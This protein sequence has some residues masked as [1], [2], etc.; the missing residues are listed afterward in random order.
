MFAQMP[1]LGSAGF[2]KVVLVGGRVSKRGGVS[3]ALYTQDHCDKGRASESFT[4]HL[5]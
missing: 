2:T 5:F 4:H 3:V 1:A